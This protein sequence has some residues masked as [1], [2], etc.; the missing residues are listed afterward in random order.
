MDW[1]VAVD[2]VNMAGARFCAYM[3]TMFWQVGLLVLLLWI[4]DLAVRRIPQVS[5]SFRYGLW[6]LVVV[7]LALPPSFTLPT[8]LLG[9]IELAPEVLVQPVASG[10]MK[11]ETTAPLDDFVGSATPEAPP[12]VAMDPEALLSIEALLFVG[13]LALVGWLLGLLMVRYARLHRDIRRASSVSPEL[14]ER[15]AQ[16]RARL[17][18]TVP[19]RVRY[20][21]RVSGP[22]ICGVRRPVLM[23]PPNLA[24]ELTE[25]RLESILCHELVHV[26]RRD[27]FVSWLQ[28]I[29][30]ILFFF[31]PMVWFANR[32]IRRVRELAVDQAVLFTSEVRA[33]H[34][35]ETL[36]RVAEMAYR[37]SEPVICFAGL[38]ES[39]SAL[40]ERIS[41]MLRSAPVRAGLGWKGGML[42]FL[43]GAVLLPMGRGVLKEAVASGIPAK[44]VDASALQPASGAL[45]KDEFHYDKQAPITAG[46][47]LEVRT[48][49]GRIQI[50]GGNHEVC[51]VKANVRIQAPTAERVA[52][53]AAQVDLEMASEKGRLRVWVRAPKLGKYEAVY[54][55][56]DI[57]APRSI[58]VDA[59]TSHGKVQAVNVDGDVLAR[60]SHGNLYLENIT[61][62]VDGQTS[63]GNVHAGKVQ[64]AVDARTSHGNIRLDDVRGQVALETSHGNIS[65]R[66]LISDHLRFDARFGNIDFDCTPESRAHSDIEARI[67]NGQLTAQLPAA[68]GGSVD[69]QTRMGKVSCAL[70]LKS[71]RVQTKDQ[72]VGAIGEGDGRIKLAVDIGNIDIKSL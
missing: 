51:R 21:R 11:L 7:K 4:V 17:K 6:L 25:E 41:H 54:S 69:A 37:R 72:L 58:N 20:S 66:R 48:E 42:V 65:G 27:A 47:T 39:G 57:T 18:I 70:P 12:M 15:V 30:Q 68:F 62:A 71:S 40:K 52:A 29:L 26:K 46:D 23:L 61:G 45:D 14:Q 60:T 8:G 5:A 50:S 44:P 67:S 43:I 1:G 3:Q 22:L 19:V 59:H 55:D 36:I 10:M 33:A 35:S 2:W 56:Y 49:H 31:H 9:R 63:H 24:E 34:Y 32:M 16:C 53:I 64:G 28:S 38:S 13:W